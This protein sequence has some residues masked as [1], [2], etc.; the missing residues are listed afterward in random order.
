MT[1]AGF[2]LDLLDPRDALTAGEVSM[3]AQQAAFRWAVSF[4]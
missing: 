2:G 4:K 3:E 1:A